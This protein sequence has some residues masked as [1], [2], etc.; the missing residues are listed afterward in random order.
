MD[1]GDALYWEI[2]NKVLREF[3]ASIGV[4]IPD[5]GEA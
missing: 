1:D 5:G 2:D 3:A 4:E